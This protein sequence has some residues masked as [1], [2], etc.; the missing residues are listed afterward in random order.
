VGVVTTL[1]YSQDQGF[2]RC[3]YK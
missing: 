2:I 3:K 1:R